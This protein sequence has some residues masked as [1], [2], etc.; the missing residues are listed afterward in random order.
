LGGPKITGTWL[1]E[2]QPPGMGLPAIQRTLALA[3]DASFT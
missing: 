1:V 2:R 3:A